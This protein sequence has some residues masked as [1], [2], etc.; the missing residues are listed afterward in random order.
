MVTST[1]TLW[2]EGSR[3]TGGTG[4]A[5]HAM[6]R[7]PL[8]TA[9]PEPTLLQAE[10][11]KLDGLPVEDWESGERGKETSVRQGWRGWWGGCGEHFAVP[12]AG[13]APDPS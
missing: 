11:Q 13:S 1:L 3:W 7:V 4:I 6:I 8:T 9:G 2:F 10:V 5:M 12:C